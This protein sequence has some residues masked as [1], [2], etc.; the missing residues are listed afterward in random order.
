VS[1]K[2]K[3]N[4]IKDERWTLK[5]KCIVENL[6][7][8]GFYSQQRSHLNWCLRWATSSLFTAH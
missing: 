2:Q 6:M 4:G 5:C 8:I 1:K 3:E 7:K